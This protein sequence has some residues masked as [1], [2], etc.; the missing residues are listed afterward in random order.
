[1]AVL[2]IKIS[3]CNSVDQATITITEQAL[4]I[5][6]GPNGLGKSSLA[7]AIVSHIK[8]DDSIK[9]LIPFKHRGTPGA[10]TPTVEGA[11]S[12]RSALVF[13]EDYV[14]Q[15]VFQKDEVVKNSFDIFIRTPEYLTE[16]AEIDDLLSGIR[17]AF[18]DN[19][20]IGQVV[21]DLME[22]REAFGKPSKSGALAKNSKIHKAF[23]SGNKIANIPNA[24]KPF[25]TFIKSKE[26]AKWISWQIKG[27]EFLS[28][29]DSCPY[30][31]TTLAEAGK[32]DTA[33]AVEKEYDASAVGHINTLRT[34]IERLGKYFSPK[35]RDNLDKVT[36][37]K[38]ELTAQENGFLSGL[39]TDIDALIEKLEGLRTMSFFSF[40]DVEE[41]GDRLTPLK[42]DLGLIDKLDSDETR[43][44][45][46]P[47]NRQLDQLIAKVGSLKGKI[48]RHKDKI[49]KAIDE[50]QNCINTFLKSAG[51]KYSVEIVPEPDSYKM[52]LV[53]RDVDGHIEM[54]SRHL[55]Y[56]EKN[57]FALVLFMYQVLSEKPDLVELDDPISSFDKNKK[58]AILD[59]LFRG[60]A[61]LRSKTT[62]MLTHDIE[63]AIDVIKSTSSVFQAARPSAAF[64]SSRGGVISEVLIQR[65]DIQTFA[66]I[67]KDN[68]ATLSDPL[69]QAIYLRRQFELQD[70][71]GLEY[72]LLASLFKR[73]DVPTV[74]SASDSRPMTASE[75]AQAESKIC[76][77]LPGF[78]YDALI[79]DAKSAATIKAKFHATNVGYEKIQ[80]FRILGSEHDHDVIRKFI[81][82]SYHI[83]NEYVM[84]LNP[85][86]FEIVPEYVVEECVRLLPA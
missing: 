44:T 79:A 41:V 76:V 45:V 80:L 78:D 60:K 42:I 53:H 56:G 29:S 75:R 20:D 73:R 26:P 63:P 59:E 24:L 72:N 82:E 43:T 13:D 18:A 81:N 64:L 12:F 46:D 16:L 74:Q 40:R 49:R 8:A 15:F 35:C 61:S 51:Y 67:C 31:S 22:L 65:D 10:G 5:K 3:N 62:L 55:S 34:I 71:M 11:N 85:H 9:D 54:A 50:N 14:D 27:N 25:E 86:R 36:K 33:L 21:K 23:G 19:A 70:D 57:A 84:Q 38:I 58:F 68:I 69:I 37:A 2:N 47:I 4:N 83:E 6:Y 28:L 1:M 52:K 77:H 30:C 7:R 39:K 66:K 32:K 48:N 17:Q